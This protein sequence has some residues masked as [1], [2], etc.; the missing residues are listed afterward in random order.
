[1]KV[2]VVLLALTWSGLW[3][4]PD[5]QGQR[6]FARGE[7]AKAAESF[8]D[9]QWRGVAWF[10][11]GEFQQAQQE[12]A[13]RSSA[14]SYYNEANCWVM[15]GKYDT[16]VAQY[17]R[18]LKLRPDWKEAKD[19]RD[20]AAA[21]AKLTEQKGGDLGDQREGADEVV[22]DQKKPS[23]GQDTVIAGEQATSD[24]AIQALWLRRVQTKPADFLKAKFAYQQSR[25]A[26]GD[27]P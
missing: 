14:E 18:A 16:A 2:V 6:Y 12:F 7:F 21:R 13:R 23:G 25:Q 8:R 9:P 20:L 15:L 5:Q 27:S 3:L 11:A 22:F 1:M 10:R 26:Q 4:T 24:A 17:E 19:N